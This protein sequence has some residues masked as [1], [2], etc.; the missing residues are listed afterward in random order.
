VYWQ[1]VSIVGRGDVSVKD[2]EQAIL[3]F[4]EFGRPDAAVE[5]LTLYSGRGDRR[6]KPQLIADVLERVVQESATHT[7]AWE[8]FA[9]DIAELLGVLQ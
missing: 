6:F 7:M 8:S 3:K 5:L 9:D 2:C 1:D 4:L